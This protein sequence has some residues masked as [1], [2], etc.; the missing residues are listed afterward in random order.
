MWNGIKVVLDF[1]VSMFRS[2]HRVQILATAEEALAF[3]K[4]AMLAV[5][6]AQ[7]DQEKLWDALA[8]LRTRK[9][10]QIADLLQRELDCAVKYRDCRGKVDELSRRI[11]V[12]EARTS[13]Q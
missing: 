10:A 5:K 3:G 12:L 11:T 6:E 13:P 7:M 8:E 9:D 1:I 4:N 2:P